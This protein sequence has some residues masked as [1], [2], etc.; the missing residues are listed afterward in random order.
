MLKKILLSALLLSCTMAHASLGEFLYDNNRKAEAWLADLNEGNTDVGGVRW[1]YYA[2]NLQ[3]SGP[4]VILV[5]G[6]T[7]EA[8][9]WFRFARHLDKKTCMIAPDLPGFGQSPYRSDISYGIGAQT[10]RLHDFL[11]KLRPQG[12]YDLLGSSMG[13]QIVLFYTLQYPAQVASLTLFDAGG[14][15]P[16]Q[17]SDQTLLIERT[18]RSA[19]DIR[20]RD[21]FTPF[22]AMGMHDMPWMPGLVK[23]HLADEF[24]E[25]NARYKSIFSQIYQKDFMDDRLR[26]VNTPTL[27][28]WGAYDRLLHVSMADVFQHGIKGSKKIILTDIGH[29]PFLENPARSANIYTKFH[30]SLNGPEQTVKK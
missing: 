9:N 17:K 2:R 28:I 15:I 5:H 8:A 27:I 4:C 22:L 7:A 3:S 23:N 10:A 25:R 26:E 20:Q 30:D 1:H 13:G 16:P 19:F 24:I 14:V 29:L 21:D 11:N 18:G 6:F 12:K